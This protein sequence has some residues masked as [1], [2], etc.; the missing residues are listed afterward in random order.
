MH[1]YGV[2]LQSWDQLPRSDAL[3]LAVAHEEFKRRPL[4]GLL[5]KL[6]PG[7]LVVDVKCQMDP[8]QLRAKG[9]AV[10]RL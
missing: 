5:A 3:V 2:K 9:V 8:Q 4:D 10:W 1:E 6:Q 7:G